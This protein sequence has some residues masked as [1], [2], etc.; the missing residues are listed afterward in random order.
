MNKVIIAGSRTITD[1]DKVCETITNSGFIIDEVVSGR[2]NGVDKLGEKWANECDKPI[3]PFPADWDDLSE[4]CILRHTKSGKPYNALSGNKRN[5]AMAE[6]A[7]CLIVIWDGKSKGSKD[8]I[9]EA[10]KQGLF[11]YSEII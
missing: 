1:Y 3:K 11:I 8:M 7:D 10:E 2:A 9:K 4:P 6:Y 5:K